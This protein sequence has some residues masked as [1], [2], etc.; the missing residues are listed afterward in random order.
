MK[1]K[2][3]TLKKEI[4]VCDK[5]CPLRKC[6]WPRQNPGSFQMGRGYRSYGYSRDKE[7]LCGTRN[8]HGCPYPLPESIKKEGE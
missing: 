7:W 1:T 3:K 6:Y 2:D 4:D 5:D 8:A